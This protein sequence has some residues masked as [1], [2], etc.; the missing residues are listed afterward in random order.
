M[1]PIK[2]F[3]EMLDQ[4][5]PSRLEFS[6]HY[7][8]KDAQRNVGKGRVEEFLFNPEGRLLHVTQTTN[9]RGLARFKAYYRF[10]RKKI[11]LIVLDKNPD[12]LL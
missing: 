9:T 11:L 6:S 5:D 8:E 2:E 1:D 10:S 4:T 12:G 7:F 3:T